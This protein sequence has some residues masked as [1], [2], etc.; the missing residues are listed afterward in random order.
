MMTVPSVARKHRELTATFEEA[1]G[2]VKSM[3]DEA[4]LQLQPKEWWKCNQFI[5]EA[6]SPLRTVDSFL[7][8]FWSQ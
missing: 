8:A 7:K 1:F 2:A 4:S 3:F 5:S 6:Q